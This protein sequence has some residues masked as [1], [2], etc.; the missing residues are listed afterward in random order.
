MQTAPF[1]LVVYS[2]QR[3]LSRWPVPLDRPERTYYNSIVL[4]IN[5]HQAL[6]REGNIQ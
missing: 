3:D 5:I 2:Q 4:R 6:H 1:L